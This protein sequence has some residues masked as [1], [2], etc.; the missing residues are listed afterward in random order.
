[1]RR[2]GTHP[3][4]ALAALLSFLGVATRPAFSNV[5]ACRFGM[6][7]D[8]C[9]PGDDLSNRDTSPSLTDPSC[10]T[11][12]LVEVDQLISE[13]RAD[14]GGRLDLVI[15]AVFACTFVAPPKSALLL[16]HRSL[17]PPLGPPLWLLKQ[18]FLV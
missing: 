6:A 9:C 14:S 1:M 10:C 3:I 18:S 2:I 12:H 8:S 16:V 7:D 13:T 17:P 5:S 15:P 4:F 11:L